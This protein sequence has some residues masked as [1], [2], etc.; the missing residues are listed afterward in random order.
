[1]E[2]QWKILFNDYTFWKLMILATVNQEQQKF[3][4][5]LLSL[6]LSNIVSQNYHLSYPV[7]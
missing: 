3:F 5:F 4:L 7:I 2:I 6:T 1:M